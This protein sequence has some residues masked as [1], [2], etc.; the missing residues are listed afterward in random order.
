M[1][2]REILS[3]RFGYIEIGDGWV[4]L[5][6][7]LVEDLD[8][9]DVPYI[10]EQIKEKFGGLRFYWSIDFYWAKKQDINVVRIASDTMQV[11]VDE[12]EKQSYTIC[13]VCGKPGK[14]TKDSWI[15]TLCEE[16]LY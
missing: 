6:S 8:S 4:D 12:A 3:K 9:F 13:E 1:T 7:K 5:V 11:L 15:K 2:K 10:V 14:P 16:H